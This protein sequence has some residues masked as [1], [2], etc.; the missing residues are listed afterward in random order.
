MLLASLALQQVKEE[1][2]VITQEK[3][4]TE[5]K[6]QNCII[7]ALTVTIFG[8]VMFAFLHLR[9]VNLC[10]GCML[11]N[12]VKIIFILDVQYYVPINY[13][14]LQQASIYS[15]LQD[16]KTRKCKIK[17]K[18]HL[19]YYRNRLEGGQCDS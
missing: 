12:A 3:V 5:S 1:G 19:G 8:L 9:K 14:K 17:L 4:P 16:N 13:V 15:K 6:V 10:R 7:L 2:V 11:S 18:L